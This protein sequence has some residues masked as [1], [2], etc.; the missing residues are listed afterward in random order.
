MESLQYRLAAD[1]ILRRADSLGGKVYFAENRGSL[2]L[3]G[4][5]ADPTGAV[6]NVQQ[7]PTEGAGR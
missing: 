4:I 2:G 7:W 1:P 5:L 3:A 6:L